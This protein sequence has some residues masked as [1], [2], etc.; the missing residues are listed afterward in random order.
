MLRHNGDQSLYVFSQ[1]H[2]EALRLRC[3]VEMHITAFFFDAKCIGKSLKYWKLIEISN[4]FILGVAYLYQDLIRL[5][6]LQ[7]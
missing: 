3:S 6:N 7:V 5:P 2:R 4:R 1:K